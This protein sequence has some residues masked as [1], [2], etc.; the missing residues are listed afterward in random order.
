MR[1][2]H[3]PACFAPIYGCGTHTKSTAE[4]DVT[5]ASGQC[6]RHHPRDVRQSRVDARPAPLTV[7]S[8]VYD[9]CQFWQRSDLA[10]SA[11]S[12]PLLAD[13]ARR[14]RGFWLLTRRPDGPTIKII[15]KLS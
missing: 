1:A 13:S 12:R 8:R 4:A 7:T 5:A 2:D 11:P 3:F 6:H 15:K 9:G 14:A 10:M